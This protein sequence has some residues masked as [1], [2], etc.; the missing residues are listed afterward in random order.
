MGGN[1]GKFVRTKRQASSIISVGD[2]SITRTGL[3]H[4]AA[5]IGGEG[6]TLP[7]FRLQQSTAAKA[8]H[9]ADLDDG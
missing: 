5:W 7:P 9:S 3:K 4:A 8:D 6:S 2:N 1:V